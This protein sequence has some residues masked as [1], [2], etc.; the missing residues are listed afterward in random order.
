MTAPD[1]PLPPFRVFSTCDGSLTLTWPPIAGHR[2]ALIIALRPIDASLSGAF[3]AG[4]LDNDLIRQPVQPEA[5]RATI[6]VPAG[7]ELYVALIV[8]DI[9][10]DIITCAPVTP[11]SGSTGATLEAPVAHDS[12]ADAEIP[13]VF[14]HGRVPAGFQAMTRRVAARVVNS[15]EAPDTA[16]S[17]GCFGSRQRWTL[18]RLQWPEGTGPL[19]LVVRDSFIPPEALSDWVNCPPPDAVS[20]PAD[21]RTL[22]DADAEH[23][24]VRFYVLLRGPA[25]WHA[26]PLSPVPPPFDV[27]RP[28]HV[29]GD[30]QKRL[31]QGINSIIERLDT[32]QLALTDLEPRLTILRSAVAILNE[33]SPLKV[34]VDRAVQRWRSGQRS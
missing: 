16:I 2:G 5:G 4:E 19:A 23:D 31:A 29:L 33:G 14:A 12:Q 7:R 11:E 20:L 18:T 9:R 10:G 15:E 22:I 34:Q 30:L 17:A 6:Y 1:R 27:D 28:P 32:E 13:L 25:P 24:T 8:R 3:W 26:A 21:A